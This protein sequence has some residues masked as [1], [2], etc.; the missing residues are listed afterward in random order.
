M[1]D[2]NFAAD[3][4]ERTAAGLQARIANV[5]RQL[6]SGSMLG[7]EDPVLVA[8]R[9]RTVAESIDRADRLIGEAITARQIEA[10]RRRA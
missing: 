9:C 1:T 4:I 3:E 2:F 5:V 7:V 6:R 8:Q 10:M